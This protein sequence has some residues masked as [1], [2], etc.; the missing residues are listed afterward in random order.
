LILNRKV[1]F[2]YIDYFVICSSGCGQ[3]IVKNN[4]CVCTFF[5]VCFWMIKAKKTKRIKKNE[6]KL[7]DLI[8]IEFGLYFLYS[9]LQS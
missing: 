1:C 7:N 6:K 4:V 9:G 3:N 2:V 8:C 5:Y